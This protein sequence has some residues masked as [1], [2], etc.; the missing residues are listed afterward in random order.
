MD[1]NTNSSK[2]SIGS[3]NFGIFGKGSKSALDSFLI[4]ICASR[5]LLSTFCLQPSSFLFFQSR[6]H[7]TRLTDLKIITYMVWSVR[8]TLLTI[9]SVCLV[10][11][12]IAE[13][14]LKYEIN[15][16]AISAKFRQRAWLPSP[17]Q[18]PQQP[19][20]RYERRSRREISDWSL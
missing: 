13:K 11:S 16:M 19:F 14:A 6:A 4:E 20:S 15:S 18:K 3:I 9:S 7:R 8:S 5:S 1:E 10:R 17:N 12:E 2:R